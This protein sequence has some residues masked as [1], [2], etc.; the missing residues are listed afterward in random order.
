[1]KLLSSCFIQE[2]TNSIKGEYNVTIAPK[3]AQTTFCSIGLK[4]LRDFQAV[5]CILA[6][7]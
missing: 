3:E 5:Y 7:G 2:E 6:C 1:M 4:T